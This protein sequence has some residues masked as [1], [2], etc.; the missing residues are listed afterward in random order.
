MVTGDVNYDLLSPIINARDKCLT[1]YDNYMVIG[2]LNL[3]LLC[4]N[5]N[6]NKQIPHK[7]F[8]NLIEKGQINIPVNIYMTSNFPGLVQVL[9]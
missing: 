1:K 3:V 9:K 4:P 5:D 6:T 8:I 7:Q 2:D